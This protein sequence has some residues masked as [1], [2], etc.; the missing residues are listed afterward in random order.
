[1]IF[2]SSE[3]RTPL[4][5]FSID[6]N[7]KTRL[8][9]HLDIINFYNF[10]VPEIE[11]LNMVNIGENNNNNNDNMNN[12]AINQIDN[13]L[14][15][16]Y[17]NNINNIKAIKRNSF[18]SAHAQNLSPALVRKASKLLAGALNMNTTNDN[19]SYSKQRLS[20]KIGLIS[21]KQSI[22]LNQNNNPTTQNSRVAN[23]ILNNN[24]N[25]RLEREI[26]IS[27]NSKV[28]D[29]E[30]LLAKVFRNENCFLY[31]KC[32]SSEEKKTT[33]IKMLT[34]VNVNSSSNINTNNQYANAVVN[35][36]IPERPRFDMQPSAAAAINTNN[37]YNYTSK[38]SF[39]NKKKSIISNNSQIAKENNSNVNNFNNSNVNLNL[40]NINNLLIGNAAAISAQSNLNSNTLN[41]S[42]FLSNH[43]SGYSELINYFKENNISL[44][45]FAELFH[46]LNCQFNLLSNANSDT[47]SNSNTNTNIKIGAANANNINTN[48]INTARSNY[49]SG[50]SYCN[51]AAPKANSDSWDF[52][53][54]LLG[55]AFKYKLIFRDKIQPYKQFKSNLSFIFILEAKDFEM[56]KFHE[57]L[58]FVFTE[59][60]VNKLNDEPKLA[61]IILE[62]RTFEFLNTKVFANY[63]NDVFSNFDF[64]INNN[65]NINNMNTNSNGNQFLYNRNNNFSIIPE[66]SNYNNN[67][68]G[69]SKTFNSNCT[70]NNYVFSSNNPQGQFTRRNTTISINN[71]INNN[72]INTNNNSSPLLKKQ[73]STIIIANNNLNNTNNMNNKKDANSASLEEKQGMCL[74]EQTARTGSSPT[75][76]AANNELFFS[77]NNINNNSNFNV[78]C[79]SPNNNYLSTS[80]LYPNASNPISNNSPITFHPITNPNDINNLINANNRQSIN[81]N[82]SYLGASLYSCFAKGELANC[83]FL[84]SK[85]KF[86]LKATRLHAEKNQKGVFILD[87]NKTAEFF[88]LINNPNKQKKIKFSLKSDVKF[89]VKYRYLYSYKALNIFLFNFKKPKIFIF[90]TEK[91]ANDVFLYLLDN[92]EKIDKNRYNVKSYTN[93][94]VDGFIS[95]SDY[96]IYLNEMASRAFSDMSQYPVMPWVINNFKDEDCK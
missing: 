77:N 37:N 7:F 13:N 96:L 14:N 11:K 39:L 68:L 60:L 63:K 43:I 12:L 71:I 92:C 21:P 30:K 36:V 34:D 51:L 67:Q 58:N 41:S 24:K 26:C 23:T 91:E 69:N 48:D 50:D 75:R 27:I 25:L 6:A 61:S 45:K 1:M 54:V 53:S 19:N 55:R 72:N 2:E 87:Q 46:L 81:S 56:Q 20:K 47:N 79:S 66:E 18:M 59:L 57:D 32:L 84:N 76:A 90:E 29:F 40:N 95:N 5:K 88:P 93:L 64:K 62:K 35:T 38:K 4:Y 22:M 33:S 10:F 15:P 49:N 80:L 28:D 78:N 89:V 16:N 83:N 8:F 17:T 86:I 73:R 85:Y 44:N 9:T 65:H 42:A 3:I 31:K 74:T 94:W 82:N 52:Y 70:N